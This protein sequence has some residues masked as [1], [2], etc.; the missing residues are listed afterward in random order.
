VPLV[1]FTVLYLIPTLYVSL[2]TALGWTD[3]FGLGANP[4]TAT[5]RDLKSVALFVLTLIWPA[6]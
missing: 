5:V 3:V 2:D 1:V 4:T 6:V